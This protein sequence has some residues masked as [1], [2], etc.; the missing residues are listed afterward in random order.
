MTACSFLQLCCIHGRDGCTRFLEFL[1]SNTYASCRHVHMT[2]CY[3]GIGVEKVMVNFSHRVVVT[4]RIIVVAAALWCAISWEFRR[5]L[6]IVVN[7]Y[8][9]REAATLIS[10]SIAAALALA[11]GPAS[12]DSQSS[13]NA[14]I[15]DFGVISWLKSTAVPRVLASTAST[16]LVQTRRA[17]SHSKWVRLRWSIRRSIWVICS[18]LMLQTAMKPSWLLLLLWICLLLMMLLVHGSIVQGLRRGVQWFLLKHS[19]SGSF[20]KILIVIPKLLLVSIIFVRHYDWLL[21][22]L[23]TLLRMISLWAIALNAHLLHDLFDELLLVQRQL[24]L[25]LWRL[26][27]TVWE[28]LLLL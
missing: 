26:L 13:T 6:I 27:H 23:N 4:Y 7:E 8:A 17:S 22:L 10:L 19:G 2:I 15:V 3:I 20:W 5:N 16:C 14:M 21:L 25:L 24:L 28:L 1:I 9:R 11:A 18:K 12:E